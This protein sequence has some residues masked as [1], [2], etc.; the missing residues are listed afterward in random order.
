M[1]FNQ[2]M[3]STNELKEFFTINQY[4]NHSIAISTEHSMGIEFDCKR[5]NQIIIRNKNITFYELNGNI[6]TLKM[7]GWNYLNFLSALIEN[8]PFDLQDEY[9]NIIV[10]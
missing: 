5:C 9:Y 4:E 7:N 3:K 10:K 8:I 2:F 6:E 1:T